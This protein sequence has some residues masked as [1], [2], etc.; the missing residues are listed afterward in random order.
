[1]G[2]NLEIIYTSL[3]V[4]LIAQSPLVLQNF[5]AFHWS[6]W[7]EMKEKNKNKSVQK[8]TRFHAFDRQIQRQGF[9]SESITSLSKEARVVT[10][11]CIIASIRRKSDQLARNGSKEKSD[12]QITVWKGFIQQG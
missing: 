2:N 9:G 5:A 4:Q 11:S 12:L 8:V 1:M 7:P 10:E 6:V 3:I